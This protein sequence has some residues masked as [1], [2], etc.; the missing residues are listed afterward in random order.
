MKCSVG[1]GPFC[2]RVPPPRPH[3]LK[4]LLLKPARGAYP[5]MLRAGLFLR[6]EGPAHSCD[7]RGSPGVYGGL[8]H[9]RHSIS[10]RD[11][12]GGLRHHRHSI[13]GRERRACNLLD[14][15]RSGQVCE[16]LFLAACNFPIARARGRSALQISS[17]D[18]LA[19]T[20]GRFSRMS[21][22]GRANPRLRVFI[23]D[24]RSPSSDSRLPMRDRRGRACTSGHSL[25][26]FLL[27]AS[28]N[29]TPQALLF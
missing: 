11:V 17:T 4:L 23:S 5:Q 25:L 29:A 18:P 26:K 15:L 9:H 27:S 3:P 21:A 8:R 14:C 7:K 12:Y 1:E 20:R 22:Q 13:S 16:E 2:K 24:F 10:G 28:E 6:K 19:E